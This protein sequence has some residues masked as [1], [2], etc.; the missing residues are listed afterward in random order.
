M[1]SIDVYLEKKNKRKEAL[2]KNAKKP[3]VSK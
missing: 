2:Y 1:D 3:K